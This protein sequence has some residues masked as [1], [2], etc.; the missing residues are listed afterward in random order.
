MTTLKTPSWYAD[1]AARLAPHGLIPRGA[2]HAGPED[3]LAADVRTVALV[4]NAGPAMWEAFS[5]ARRAEDAPHE[6]DAWTDRILSAVAEELEAGIVYPFGGPPF[7]P[8]QRWAAK[9]EGLKPSPIGVLLHPDFGP[10]HAWRGALLFDMV[11]DLPPREARPH[12]CD[13]CIDKPCL[14]A[15]PVGA[16]TDAGYDWQGCRAHV[17][18]EGEACRSGGCLARHAC[19]VGA[20]YAPEQA[21]FHMAAFAGA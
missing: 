12:P 17:R 15:C 13:T 8:F 2:F 20:P 5:A 7:H 6:M 11:L 1:L 21:A 19:P 3:G 10:W 9:A 18:T 16:F 14:A 4:G